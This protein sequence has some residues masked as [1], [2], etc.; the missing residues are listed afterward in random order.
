MRE[1][2]GMSLLGAKKKVFIYSGIEQ[3]FRLGMYKVLTGQVEPVIC[4][5]HK[6]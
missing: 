3:V 6:R 4:N 1:N 2:G 5:H